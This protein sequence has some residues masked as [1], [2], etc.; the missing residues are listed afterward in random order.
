MVACERGIFVE[1]IDELAG[2]LSR[3]TKRLDELLTRIALTGCAE[4]GSKICKV[5]KISVS[6]DTL[7]RIAKAWGTDKN[8]EDITAVG[9]DDF[10]LKKNID[11]GQ[12]L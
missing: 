12:L 6:G 1:P 9:V 10:A 8:V 5:Q 11:M 2:K 7:L 3:K 4:E